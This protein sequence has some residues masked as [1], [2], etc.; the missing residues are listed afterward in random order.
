MFQLLDQV[1]VVPT[2]LGWAVC[3]VVV[4][5]CVLF[6]RGIGAR[7]LSSGSSRGK[8]EYL[9]KVNRTRSVYLYNDLDVLHQALA[10]AQIA[11][12][13]KFDMEELNLEGTYEWWSSE[14]CNNCIKEAE[15][16]IERLEEKLIKKLGHDTAM[17]KLNELIP[18]DDLGSQSF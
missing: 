11:F 8:N 2:W 14:E 18:K 10:D 17:R 13:Q 1:A 4:L 12:E 3:V 16:E 5:I 9:A 6:Y 7:Y 15:R